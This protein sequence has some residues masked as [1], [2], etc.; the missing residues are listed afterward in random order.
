MNGD[1]LDIVLVLLAVAFGVSGYRQGFIVG[2]LSF[3][4]FLTGGILG[5]IYAPEIVRW[6][7]G[8]GGRAAALVALVFVFT[9]AVLGQFL[10]SSLGVVVRNRVTWDPA[11]VVDAFGG[12]LAS[13]VSLLLIAWLLGT[14]VATSP[15]PTLAY[16][17]RNSQVLE[18]VDRVVPDIAHTWFSSFRRTVNQQEFPKVFGGLNGGDVASVPPPDKEVLQTSALRTARSS[19]VKVT[20]TAP[21]CDRRT[22]GS[23]FVY[24]P[25][26]VLTNAHVVAGVRGGVVVSTAEGRRYEGRVVLF[27]HRRDIAVLYVP[28]LPLPDLDFARRADTGD[29]AVIAGYPHGKG[30]SVVPARIRGYQRARGPGIYQ[31]HQVTREI[32]TLRARVEPGNSG[33]P[34]LS[35]RGAVYGMVFAASVEDP[36]TGYALT[37][38]EVR[39][40]A[41]KAATATDR[42]STMTCR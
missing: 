7:V 27:D 23:G 3:A 20:G 30:F 31:T 17:V 16:Q 38:S 22:E 14:A 9:A 33:G 39:T 35:P 28:E 34:L 25:R 42:V 26:H 40:V 13:V 1:V 19:V 10:T 21:G 32:Y 6:M 24:A 5:A 41:R 8:G 18:S 11:R 29:S 2:A 36:S 37:A 4:G 12:A 15:F